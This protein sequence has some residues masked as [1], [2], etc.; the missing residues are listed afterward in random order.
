M[1]KA[2]VP[3]FTSALEGQYR[4]ILFFRYSAEREM[5]TTFKRWRI[6]INIGIAPNQRDN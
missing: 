2:T 6:G 3:S 1:T 4:L 5:E